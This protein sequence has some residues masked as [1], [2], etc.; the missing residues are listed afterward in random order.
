MAYASPGLAA[1]TGAWCGLFF[2]LL[3]RR[4]WGS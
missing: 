4:W 2:G 1:Y 3:L